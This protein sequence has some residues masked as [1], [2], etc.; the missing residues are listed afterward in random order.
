MLYCLW[1]FTSS[2]WFLSQKQ[3]RMMAIK[4]YSWRDSGGPAD[5]DCLE[6]SGCQWPWN[7]GPLF[8]FWMCGGWVWWACVA[9]RVAPGHC[10]SGHPSPHTIP[11]MTSDLW[12]AHKF[13]EFLCPQ[14]YS[15]SL[16]QLLQWVNLICSRCC[17]SLVIPETSPQVKADEDLNSSVR[18]EPAAVLFTVKQMGAGGGSLSCLKGQRWAIGLL[19]FASLI[20]K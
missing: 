6:L 12:A 17:R 18:W 15:L 8:A 4:N 5:L 9:Q 2:V 1:P 11:T 16:I 3:G 13:G 14:K 7:V 20:R 19:M 10:W